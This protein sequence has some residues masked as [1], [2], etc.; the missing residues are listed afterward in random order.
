M[1]PCNCERV[2]YMPNHNCKSTK[3]LGIV[4]FFSVSS[5]LKKFHPLGILIDPHVVLVLFTLIVC[6]ATISEIKNDLFLIYF[7]FT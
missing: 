1:I 3:D 2:T 6:F 5:C 4:L 7:S